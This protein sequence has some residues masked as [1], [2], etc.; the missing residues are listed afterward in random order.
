[1]VV[2]LC[3]QNKFVTMLL[4]ATHCNFAVKECILP[5]LSHNKLEISQS[6]FVRHLAKYINN[7][8]FKL[9]TVHEIVQMTDSLR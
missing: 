5:K 3:L 4:K 7:I 1:M 6:T 9:A 8:L 2:L